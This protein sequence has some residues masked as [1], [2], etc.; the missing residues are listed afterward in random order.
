M[1]KYGVSNF[2]NGS[3]QRQNLTTTFK[4]QIAVTAATG[5]TTLRRGWIYD[6]SV[7][8]DQTPADNAI[9]WCV[10]RQTSVG[11]GTTQIAPPLDFAD[12]AALLVCTVDNTIEGI[13]TATTK[14][15]EMG[16]NQRAGYRWVAYP[17]GEFV[18]PATNV[19]GLGLRALSPAYTGKVNAALNFWE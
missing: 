18:V 5:A 6:F 12:A 10:D 9:G 13:V 15:W 16:I 1:A 4:T 19:A 7:G 17:G 14:L 11:T 8:C 3:D 2:V